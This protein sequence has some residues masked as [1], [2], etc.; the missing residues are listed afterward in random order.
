[1]H[2]APSKIYRERESTSVADLEYKLSAA[3]RYSYIYRW[4]KEE[5]RTEIELKNTT[6]GYNEKSVK[7]YSKTT[8]FRTRLIFVKLIS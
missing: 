4:S 3:R 2:K 1:M 7:I 5:K 6:E 8:N